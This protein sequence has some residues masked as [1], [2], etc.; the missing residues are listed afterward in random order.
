MPVATPRYVGGVT[1]YLDILSVRLPSA[2][3]PLPGT[4]DGPL[5]RASRRAAAK[6]WSLGSLGWPGER[7]EG[8]KANA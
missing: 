8:R 6:P 1:R 4:S 7:M 3:S 5:G 2:V